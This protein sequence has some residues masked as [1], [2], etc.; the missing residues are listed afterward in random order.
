MSIGTR[1]LKATLTVMPILAASLGVGAAS[2][3]LRT[4]AD[5]P[6]PGHASRF[7]YQSLDPTTKTLYLAHMGD[8]KLVV[9]NAKARKVIANLPGFP[10]VTGV[11]FVPEL[12]RVF[13]SV[14]REHEVVVVD[15]QTLKV[16]ARIPGGEFPDGLAYAPDPHKIFVSDERGGIETVIDAEKNQRIATIDLGGEVGNT[17]YDPIAR[18]ILANVQTRN[19][20]V[21]IDPMT[22][23]IVARHKLTGG[24]GPH[25]LLIDAPKRLAFAA[26]EHDA[27][28][29][30][31]DLNTFDVKQS[32]DTGEGPD[33]LAFD[34]TLERLYVAAESGVISIFQLHDRMME[35]LEDL[36]VAANA[37]TVSV[38]SETHEV[39][40][41]LENLGG[42]P[43]LRIMN[44]KNMQP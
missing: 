43:V 10:S 6:L 32:F 27:K 31:I 25:G 24:S 9:F 41:P 3:A 44:P 13:A 34:A 38:D 39:Y 29:L 26:C 20:L 35:K 8:G 4:V 18:Q 15:T 7:D 5:I 30:V 19:E 36:A 23:K 37:H 16:T 12:H 22:D 33:V 40:L 14:P 2:S 28:L 17:Q 42:R 21:V 11:L 1:W